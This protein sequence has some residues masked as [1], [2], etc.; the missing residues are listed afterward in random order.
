MINVKEGGVIVLSRPCQSVA[1]VLYN[2]KLNA[3]HENLYLKHELVGIRSKQ[4]NVL[5][6][7]LSGSPGSSLGVCF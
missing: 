7:T 6:T 5:A 2:H 3:N 1:P 4:P